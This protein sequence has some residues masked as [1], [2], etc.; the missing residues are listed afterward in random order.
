MAKCI[1]C[2]YKI[3]ESRSKHFNR[4]QF[5]RKVLPVLVP[6]N[7]AAKSAV[8]CRSCRAAE[9]AQIRKRM[10]DLVHAG[11]LVYREDVQHG[12]ENAPATLQRL[13]SGSNRGKQ[14]LAVA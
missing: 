3:P 10:A 7:L 13:F 2:R 14:I 4:S 5:S 9:F 6:G 1:A 8:N 11:R 12:F